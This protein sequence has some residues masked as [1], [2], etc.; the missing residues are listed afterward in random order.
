MVELNAGG[1]VFAI[2]AYLVMVLEVRLSESVPVP[3]LEILLVRGEALL[4]VW[5]FNEFSHVF[6]V[7][8]IPL[9]GKYSTP[10]LM[11]NVFMV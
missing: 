10:L 8:H 9:N 3:P 5:A 7:A 2:G 6:I 11:Y 1:I 4:C